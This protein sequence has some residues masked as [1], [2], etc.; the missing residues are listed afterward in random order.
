MDH[1]PVAE[2]LRLEILVHIVL[3]ILGHILVPCLLPGDEGAVGHI[4]H[5]FQLGLQ[6]L[7]LALRQGVVHKGHHGVFLL[8][9]GQI[10][11]GVV[12]H[13]GEGAHDQQARHSDADGGKRHEPVGE[14]AAGALFEEVTE[15]F[16]CCVTPSYVPVASPTT[17]PLSR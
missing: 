15:V 7:G 8:Q 6:G 16:H 14:H 2:H 1:I 17:R 9:V 11:V 10:L 3:V 4:V 5:L 13:Q 12:G